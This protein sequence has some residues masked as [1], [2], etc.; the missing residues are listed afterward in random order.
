MKNYSVVSHLRDEIECMVLQFCLDAT[1][2]KNP[3]YVRIFAQ[4]R[5][6]LVRD[7]LNSLSSHPY[8]RKDEDL[9]Y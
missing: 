4:R 6:C 7:L 3:D 8:P 2:P 9:P 5:L 1:D